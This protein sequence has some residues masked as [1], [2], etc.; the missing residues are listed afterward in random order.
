MGP[1]ILP[2]LT[3]TERDFKLRSFEPKFSVFF[4]SFLLR[5]ASNI[6]VKSG[7]PREKEKTGSNG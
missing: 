6:M 3:V 7:R 4:F 2:K 5:E 1:V